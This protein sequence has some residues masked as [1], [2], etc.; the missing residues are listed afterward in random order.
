MGAPVEEPYQVVFECSGRADA[1][2]SAIDQLDFAGTCVLVGTGH[3]LPRIN[4]NRVIILEN[5]I[6]GAYNY[7]AAGFGPALELLASGAMPLDAA[8][9]TGRHLARPAPRGAATLRGRRAARQGDG[10]TR[11]FAGE[12]GREVMSEPTF[13]PRL[14][15]VAI[16]MPPGE[17]DDAGRV[18]IKDF[19]GDVF[20][21][22]EGDN[23]GES[24]NPL[25]LMTGQMQFVYL[26]PGDPALECPRLDH[27]GLEV[28]S[29][30]EIEEIVAKA[31]TWQ[32]KDDRVQIIDVKARSSEGP[33]GQ[34]VLTSAYIGFLLPMMVELQ[35]LHVDLA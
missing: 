14:N 27:F 21:W 25:I 12:P 7:D 9:G 3:D 26:L 29:V 23:S 15:H 16:T 13:A 33:R 11:P 18:E 24:G 31:K 35:H 20:S 8:R 22:F 4:H 34:Y 19:Y 30:A 32:E 10:P 17:L 1:A 2:E 28:S 5:T 6:I